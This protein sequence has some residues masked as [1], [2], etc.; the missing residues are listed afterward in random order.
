[1]TQLLTSLTRERIIPLS[2]TGIERAVRGDVVKI[3]VE[4]SRRRR[5]ISAVYLGM[6]GNRDFFA[7]VEIPASQGL[8]KQDASSQTTSARTTSIAI[9][10]SFRNTHGY[11]AR[12]GL[13]LSSYHYNLEIIGPE[14]G[15][16]Y[17]EGRELLERAG[18]WNEVEGL[19]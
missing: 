5:E 14:Q 10:S 15:K 12:L 9:Y 3:S 13:M 2:T 6:K 17:N 7:A 4:G 11:H 8:G 1:M 16:K 18:L 19:N